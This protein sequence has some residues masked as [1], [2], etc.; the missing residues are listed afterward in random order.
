[1]LAAEQMGN[2][3]RDA[4]LALRLLW[5]AKT[6][7]SVAV[8]TL[9]LGIAANTAI[10]SVIYGTFFE[11]LPYR[12]ADRLV[13]VWSQQ[14]GERIP[15]SPPEFVEW[16]RQA[17][18]FEDLNAWT[19]W[20]AAVTI[21][22]LVEQVQIAPATPG[23]L[24]MLGYGQPLALGRN[25]VASEGIPGNDHVVIITHRLW[26][27]RFA[28][29]PNVVGQ[30]I[31]IDRKPY[32]VVGVLAAGPPDEN[33]SQLWVPLSFSQ[34]DL[35][36][37]LHRLLVMGRLKHGVSIEQANANL[38]AVTRNAALPG[39]R[40]ANE[41][42][43][44]VQPFRNNFLSADT[45]RGLWLALAAVAFVLLIAC[46]NVANLMLARGTIR[47]RE[48]AV[49]ISLGA[50]RSQIIGQMIVESSLLA[51]IGGVLGVALASGLLKI[52]SALMPPHMLPTEAHIRL[53]VPVLLFTL[54]ACALAGIVCGAA[55]AWQAAGAN[56]NELLKDAARSVSAT[57]NRLR[58]ALVVVE[59]ALAIT[60]LTGGG[61]AIHTLFGLANRDLG[62]RRDHL[63]TF[64]LPIGD[65]RFS[66]SAEITA[67][68]RQLLERIQTLPA[69]VAASVSVDIPLQ[70]DM[71]IPFAIVGKPDV[72][73]SKQLFA[74]FNMVSASY[75]QAFGIPI[76]R[77]RT[78]TDRDR[79]GTMPVAIVNETLARQYFGNVDP[80]T[81]RLVMPQIIPG[82]N[83]PGPPVEYQVV[84][85][86]ADIRSTDPAEDL[87][88]AI[89]VPFWQSP[90]PF[91]R[92]VVLTAGD[93]TQ[94]RQDIA[95]VIRSIDRDLPMG[96][97]KT[98]EQM[99]SES[100][101]SN[102]FNSALFGS[103]A[104]VALLL[105]AFGIYGVMSF[106]VAQRTQEIG[107][108]MALGADRHD[109]LWRTL[110]DGM[111]TVGLGAAAGSVGAFYAATAL[112]G[113][114]P[115]MLHLNPLVFVSVTATLLFAALIACVVP[116]A[117][118]ASVDPL[119][120][121]RRE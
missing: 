32:V 12:D 20:H 27:D 54:A 78:F 2:L 56:L 84:G 4:R 3:V 73:P 69:V 76:I 104:V 44:T 108:R 33:Q 8:V 109:I 38:A 72:D 77:G 60:L 121:L 115:G 110:I 34:N 45:K 96:N 52:V 90:W 93:P 25:F 117:R 87:S 71:R 28:S 99:F 105:A 61:L 41:W 113:I 40:S 111:L 89:E 42:S 62:F 75:F 6:F 102:R 51:L 39:H 55:P 80:L 100:L 7:T 22:D 14:Q 58:R 88:P 91:A 36:T 26:R 57:G 47:Q 95:A 13:M 65:N 97:V 79:A 67:F 114:I 53:N 15:A 103:F 74:R 17:T 63:L 106:V 50:S 101:V 81:Q 24:S 64:M 5:K 86:R 82:K 10:F 9:S 31:R 16:K 30:Q 37:G 112:R 68:Y 120:A 21:A 11:P 70:G 92:A 23:F 66:T 49:R 18:G 107:L 46:A 43:V 119:I 48:L 98:I 35:T 59:F 116:A 94:V 85:V 1:M 118:A 83:L 19:W 29:N